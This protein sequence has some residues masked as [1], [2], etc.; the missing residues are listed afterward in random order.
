MPRTD[1]G[2]THNTVDP[3]RKPEP[4]GGQVPRPPEISRAGH[5]RDDFAPRTASQRSHSNP[6]LLIQTKCGQGEVS[7][8]VTSASSGAMA[9]LIWTY[10][11]DNATGPIGASEVGF[12]GILVVILVLLCRPTEPGQ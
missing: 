3:R 1:D 10:V 4:V 6:W 7:L 11:V 8:P 12:C 2:R 5:D 9:T